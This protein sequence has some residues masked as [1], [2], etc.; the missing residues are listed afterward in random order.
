MVGLFHEP[1]GKVSLAFLTRFPTRRHVRWLSEKRLAA[2][3]KSAHHTRSNTR[4]PAQLFDHLRHAPAGLADG[5]T[6]EAAEA[7]TS[8]LVAL[9]RSLRERIT[10]LEG[11]IEQALAAHADQAV[12]TSLPRTG[13]VRAPRPLSEIGDPRGRYPPTTPWPPP[14]ASR[15]RPG[16]PGGLATSRSA[17]AATTG[18]A[19]PSSTSPTAAAPPP[20]GPRTSTSAPER[21]DSPRPRG[22]RPGPG[23]ATDHLALLGRPPRSARH[24]AVLAARHP[25]GDTG[26]PATGRVVT[27]IGVAS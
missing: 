13:R 9:L 25:E 11:R 6:A 14:P 7:I 24:E 26:P 18:F 3:L 12:F 27:S 8:E 10:A 5:P 22:T 15:P 4:T 2:R 21:S 16:R 23:L 19:K 20:R 1:D 17:A